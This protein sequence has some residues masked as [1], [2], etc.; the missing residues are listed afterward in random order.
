MT[1]R[2]SRKIDGQQAKVVDYE[3]KRLLRGFLTVKF[4]APPPLRGEKNCRAGL[5]RAY[6]RWVG[7]VLGRSGFFREKP[8]FP[9][10]N[11][12]LALARSSCPSPVSSR[13]LACF[14]PFP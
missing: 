5:S 2:F 12:S 9:W 1:E 8:I 3:R 10:K 11:K 6:R 7:E 13:F 4:P 14:F